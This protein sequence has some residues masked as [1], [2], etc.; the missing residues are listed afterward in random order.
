MISRFLFTLMLAVVS[1]SVTDAHAQSGFAEFRL[2]NIN[3]QNSTARFST[4][5]VQNQI[6][7]NSL[8]RFG[9]PNLNNTN[10]FSSRAR[11]T[12]QKPFSDVSRGSSVSPY[13]GLVGTNNLAGSVQNYYSLVRP[14][15]EQ[16]RINERTREV[17]MRQQQQLQSVAAQPPYAVT[18]DNDITVTGHP[19]VFN[20]TLGY[21]PGLQQ[22]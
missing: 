8:P 7:R 13:F 3:N 5:R 15:L 9:L 14:Q 6:Y 11:N 22:R 17:Q 2:N 19:A 21:Y 4:N 18:G 10:V 12:P 20:N 1:A 16:Q